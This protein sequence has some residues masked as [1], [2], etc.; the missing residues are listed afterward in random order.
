MG[1]LRSASRDISASRESVAPWSERLGAHDDSLAVLVARPGDDRRAWRTKTS[2]TRRP[3][4]D[5][6]PVDDRVARAGRC[7]QVT[8]WF[9]LKRPALERHDAERVRHSELGDLARHSADDK[10]R[11]G[12][13]DVPC[14]ARLS[15]GDGR[16]AA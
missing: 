8:G 1:P 9:A 12:A 6:V 4:E 16:A 2:G 7:P 15:S 10:A 13:G 11:D 14:S 3:R 5:A